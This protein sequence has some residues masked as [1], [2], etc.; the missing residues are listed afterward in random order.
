VKQ[1]LIDSLYLIALKLVDHGI[2]LNQGIDKLVSSLAQPSS[3]KVIG[4]IK[5]VALY[6]NVGK[7]SIKKRLS[8]GLKMGVVQSADV[9]FCKA[10]QIILKSVI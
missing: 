1:R 7:N 2:Q 8:S 9:L 4:R 3:P 6:R 10:N 5:P